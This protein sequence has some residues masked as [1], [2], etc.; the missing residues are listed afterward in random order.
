MINFC[1]QNYSESWIKG[2]FLTIILYLA[3]DLNKINGVEYSGGVSEDSG[4]NLGPCGE[5][6]FGFTESSGSG[7]SGSGP[8]RAG[9]LSLGSDVSGSGIFTWTLPKKF[10]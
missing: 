5:Q 10:Q 4:G 9:C 6:G 2:N 7:E 8:E 3:D 1:A